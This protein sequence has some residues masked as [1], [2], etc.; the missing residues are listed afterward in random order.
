M[1]SRLFSAPPSA[2]S[3]VSTLIVKVTY[4]CN[5][6]CLYC[7]EKVSKTGQDMSIEQFKELVELSLGQ[8]SSDQLTFLFHGGEPTLL[9]IAWYEEALDYALALSKS[10]GKRV[11]FAMQ[12]NLVRLKEEYIQ[13]FQRYKIQL[14]VSLDQP[15]FLLDDSQRG[16]ETKVFKNFRRL[17]AAKV[18]AGVLATINSSN[19]PNFYTLCEWLWSEAQQRSF[20]AN[21]VTPVGLPMGSPHCRPS[22]FL[23]PKK[24]LLII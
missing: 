12:S 9:P 23:W 19:Y 22:K 7:Y 18:K 5:L 13:L 14:G 2:F 11:S 4:R 16:G 10:L 17:Q 1:I 6:D 8:T 3:T 24:P 15:V 21:V 20:K